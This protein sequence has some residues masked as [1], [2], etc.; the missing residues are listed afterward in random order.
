MR[1]A[2]PATAAL[3]VL[4]TSP[5]SRAEDGGT[6]PESPP[7]GLACL[8]RWYPVTPVKRDGAW[9]A[10]LPDG[11]TIPYDDGQAKTFEQRLASP[12]I[13]DLYSIPYRKGPIAPV[14]AQDEDPGRIRS[15]LLLGAAYG[16]K[17][18]EVDLVRVR[19][20]GHR[21]SV[22]RKVGPAFERVAVRLERALAA[23]ASLRP[24]VERLGGAFV[25]RTIANSRL[26]SA[27]SYGIALDIN[28]RYAHYWEWQRPVEP[29]RWRNLV[30]AAIVEAF[31]AEGFIW[32]GRWYHY[33]TMHFEYR[34]E[35]LDP[36]CRQP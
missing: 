16:R 35:L 17:A 30:P 9:L 26:R 25:W 24:F 18:A 34:P 31:E 28:V 36:A 12:D 3:L 15:E 11:S 4:L 5:A 20:L 7:A 29:V 19:F 10:A 32:G 8:S 33:D 27:H 1:L 14:K 6:P 13:E 21:V 2:R 22:H 23:D